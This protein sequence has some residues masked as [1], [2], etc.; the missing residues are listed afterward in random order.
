MNVLNNDLTMMYLRLC[1][2][3]KTKIR[4]MRM[5]PSMVQ[6]VYIVQKL[7]FV[8]IIYIEEIYLLFQTDRGYNKSLEK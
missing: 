3:F 5:W 7:Y 8:T 6:K 2:E 4:K 1:Y